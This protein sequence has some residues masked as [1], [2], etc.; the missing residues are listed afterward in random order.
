MAYEALQNS[1]FARGIADLLGDLADL[2]QK[3]IR[4]ARAE[5]TE[6]ISRRLEASV[7][8]VAAGLLAFIAAILVIEAIVFAIA[9]QGL[10]LHWSCL[11]V[12]VAVAAAG[13][14]A[15]SYGRSSSQE[16]LVP[17]R[18]VRQINEDLRTAKEQL[19]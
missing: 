5:V 11:V 6:K 17:T 13:G 19:S 16:S 4:L 14:A 9:S 8:F 2:V 3:E 10:A 7:W 18:S 15:F 1:A 12:A